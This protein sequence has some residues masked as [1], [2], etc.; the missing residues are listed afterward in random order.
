MAQ[1][2]PGVVWCKFRTLHL[3]L[4]S[5]NGVVLCKTLNAIKPKTVKKSAM[6]PSTMPFKQMEVIKA[7]LSG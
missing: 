4:V 6:K 5:Q 2:E 1:G 3:V 7:F